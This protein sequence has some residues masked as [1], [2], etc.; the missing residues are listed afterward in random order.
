MPSNK[1]QK[2]PRKKKV[3][4]KSLI[5]KK[6]TFPYTEEYLQLYLDLEDKIITYDEFVNKCNDLFIRMKSN[7]NE[8]EIYTVTNY[9]K[10]MIHRK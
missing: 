9:I 8:L 2:Q 10:Q 7:L 4:V 6:K 5:S 3:D 1:H